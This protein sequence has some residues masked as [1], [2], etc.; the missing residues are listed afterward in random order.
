MNPI[1]IRFARSLPILLLGLVLAGCASD[2][3]PPDAGDLYE[4]KGKVVMKDGTPVS[5]GEIV[6]V[7]RG[8]GGGHEARSPIGSDG[9]FTLTTY[10]DPGVAPGEYVAWLD[11]PSESMGPATKK[12]GVLQAPYDRKYMDEGTS[13]LMVTIKPEPNQLDLQLQ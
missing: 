3:S 7:P 9:S 6:L 10:G 11:T 2:N 13:D 1:S 8:E 4:A 5:G 12:K